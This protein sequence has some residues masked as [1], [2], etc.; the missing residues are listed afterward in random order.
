MSV[1]KVGGDDDCSSCVCIVITGEADCEDGAEM[2]FIV[3]RVAVHDFDEVV[4]SM[5]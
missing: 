1:F 3:V 5:C 4:E 2:E